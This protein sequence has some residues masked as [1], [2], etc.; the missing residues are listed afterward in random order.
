M[1]IVTNDEIGDELEKTQ[2][3]LEKIKKEL[4]GAEEKNGVINV[5][6]NQ[7]IKS[8]KDLTT[9]IAIL[10]AEKIGLESELSQKITEID[11]L[12]GELSQKNINIGQME[13]NIIKLD[14]TIS[15]N[16]VKINELETEKTELHNINNKYKILVEHMKTNIAEYTDLA[17][18][19]VVDKLIDFVNGDDEKKAIYDIYLKNNINENFFDTFE[20]DDIK[21][22]EYECFK[23]NILYKLT[24]IVSGQLAADSSKITVNNTRKL[25][26]Y[27]CGSEKSDL[28]V[29]SQGL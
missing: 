1:P 2:E 21:I 11:E 3:E 5:L 12:G 17:D 28:N 15:K 8:N 24:V 10:D 29:I 26:R 14:D 19:F 4:E 27:I 18:D 22:T 25:V 16:N 20:K 7:F 9:K 13:N 6:L 23:S